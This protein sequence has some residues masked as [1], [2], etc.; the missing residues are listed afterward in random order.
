[1][2]KA[3]VIGSGIAGL[4]SAIRL[5]CL[6]LHVHVFEA[7]SYPGGK[8]SE[9]SMGGFRNDAGPSLFT[10]PQLVDDLFILAGRV[11]STFFNYQRLEVCCHYFYEDGTFLKAYADRDKLISEFEEKL[12][13][14]SSV[15]AAYLERSKETYQNAGEIFLTHSLHKLRTWVSTKVVKALFKI[16]RYGIFKTMNQLNEDQLQHPKLVQLFNR[17]ATYNGSNPYQAPGILTAIPHLEFNIGTYLPKGGMHQITVA[18]YKLAVDLGVKFHFNSKVT[19]IRTSSNSAKGIEVGGDFVDGDVIVCN[20]DVYHAYRKLMPQVKAPERVLSQ[21]RSSSALIFYW[22]I[23]HTFPQLDLH[24]IFFSADYKEEFACLFDKKTVSEDPTVYINITSKYE[25][26][27]APPGKENWFV[28]V[29]VPANVGQD[30]TTIK[31]EVKK[32]VLKKVSRQLK[33]DVETL[34]ETEEILDPVTIESKTSSYQ[35]SLYG[36]S[37]NSKFAAFLRHKNFS[38][39]F[40]N[41]FFCGGSVHPGGGIPLCLL[42]AKIVGD[43]V[44]KKFELRLTKDHD[45]GTKI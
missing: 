33:I 34:I 15:V 11:P 32:N 12:S 23:N 26:G 35:G 39:Q 29:N 30:W 20:M 28:M 14:P 18:L 22:G 3:I 45:G 2:E 41:L 31:S 9:F 27:D 8:L 16:H 25:E 36:T 7:N 21:E 38:S 37:S 42:S 19:A 5:S 4:A 10:L 24:N 43:L 17:Y 1:M 44:A 13:V 40:S 6:G